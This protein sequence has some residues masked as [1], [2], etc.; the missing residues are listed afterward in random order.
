MDPV[1]ESLG[2][3][4]Q[5]QRPVELAFNDPLRRLQL[6]RRQQL[7]GALDIGCGADDM[8]ESADPTEQSGDLVLPGDV[9]RDRVQRGRIAQL[10]AGAFQPALIAPGDDNLSASLE[11]P[12]CQRQTH[13]RTAADDQNFAVCHFHIR[14]LR[15]HRFGGT[16]Q[17]GGRRGNGRKR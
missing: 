3:P 16:S 15:F 12:P 5:E 10:L 14:H 2:A 11:T 6:E 13:S 8:V 7:I 9:D 17:I 1:A 4:C